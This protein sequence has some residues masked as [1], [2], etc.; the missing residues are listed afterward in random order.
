MTIK[1]DARRSDLNNRLTYEF[2]ILI[3][4]AENEEKLASSFETPL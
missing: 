4:M 1:D 3:A 2:V